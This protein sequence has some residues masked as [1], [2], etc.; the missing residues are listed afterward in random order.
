VE[1][2]TELRPPLRRPAGDGAPRPSLP[3]RR[4]RRLSVA[5]LAVL[6]AIGSALAFVVWAGALS[7]REPVVAA[8]RTVNAGEVLSR[9]DLKTVRVAAETD[10]ATV[11][12][13]DVRELVGKVTTTP[14]FKG[15]LVSRDQVSR[16]APLP[17]DQAIVGVL[18]K[19]GQGPL[20]SL[21]VGTTVQ[22]VQTV[23]Q[24]AV[25]AG[26]PEVLADAARVFA[27]STP[28]QGDGA[29]QVGV[30]GSLLVSLRVPKD[31]AAP[32]VSAADAERIRLVVVGGV[33]G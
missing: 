14:L 10:V 11:P 32:I 26:A 16:S 28:S 2:T 15:A 12:G 7:K 19:P 24:S 8:A 30:A 23:G 6:V 22:V 18:V 3:V 27:V 5:L 21:R 9:S 29:A 4:Q 13:G 31:A 17:S 1:T 20:A 33:T 25:S